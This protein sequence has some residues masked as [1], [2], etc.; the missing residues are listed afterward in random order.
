MQVGSIRLYYTLGGIDHYMYAEPVG[1]Y[2]NVLAIEAQELVFTPQMPT[3]VVAGEPF[4][5][6]L[7]L[8]NELG[9]Q[10]LATLVAC[11]GHL[12]YFGI[13]DRL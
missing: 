3:G 11:G 6:E 10:V 12:S 9:L 13:G 1:G 4:E 7:V 5:V 2:I 8:Q